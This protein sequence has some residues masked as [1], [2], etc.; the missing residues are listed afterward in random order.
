MII[1]TLLFASFAKAASPTPP[2]LVII[3]ADDMGYSDPGCYGGEISTPSIDKLADQGVRLTR[4]RN[5]GMCVISRTSMLTGEWWPR[6]QREFEKTPL[7][8]EKLHERGYATALIGKWHLKGDPMDRGFDHFF[9]FLGGFSDHFAGSP[10][11]RLDRKPFTDFGKDYYSSDAFTDRAIDFVKGVPEDKPFFLYLSYQAPHNPLEAPA[12]DIKKYRGKYGNGWQ[13]VREARFERQKKM[14]IFPP[15]A[16]LPPYPDNLP[17]WNSLTPEQKNLEDLR[18]SVFAAMVTRMDTGIGRVMEALERSG[19]A[20]NTMVLFMSD[21]GADPFSSLDPMLL[22]RGKLP[23]DP[24]SNYQLGIGAAY[25]SV[26]PWRLY[27]ISQHGGGITTG[28]IVWWP[29][30]IGKAGRLEAAPLHMIDVLPTL[31][32]A[33]G[34]A[35]EDLPGKSFLPLLR[36]KAWER[37]GPLYFQY[38]DN[39]AVRDGPWTLAEVDG[40]GWELFHS[41]RDP[42]EIRDLA[43][44]Q[45]DEVKRLGG[46][47]LDWWKQ[48][49]AS[50]GYQPKSTRTGPDYK[51]QGDRGSGVEYVPSAMPEELKGRTPGR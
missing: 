19:R 28:G 34:T 14:G 49:N 11:Y 13:A 35:V 41:D 48:E 40:N 50:K 31:M 7:V 43:K 10:D 27:K 30:K 32:D 6:G 17:D 8:S 22:K 37:K 47:W 12:A 44:E 20:D 15:D 45:P 16:K 3:L 18:M 2:N 5:C 36:G 9:G 24:R 38:M 4:F 1:A 33:A 23:G 39:R 42:L 51:P 46:E 21:N 25:A 26:S 29:G